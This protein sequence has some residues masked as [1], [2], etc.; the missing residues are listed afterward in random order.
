[1][2]WAY[3]DPVTHQIGQLIRDI[4]ASG[5]SLEGEPDAKQLAKEQALAHERRSGY[6]G[7]YPRKSHTIASN[8]NARRKSFGYKDVYSTRDRNWPMPNR[9]S[10]YNKQDRAMKLMRAKLDQEQEEGSGI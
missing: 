7:G 2:P 10:Y 3:P 5:R 9:K 4:D 6:E 1:M 8:R